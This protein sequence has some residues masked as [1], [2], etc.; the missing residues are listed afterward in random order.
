ML[1]FCPREPQPETRASA[2]PES[3]KK[4]VSLGLEVALESGIGLSSDHEDEAY[5]KAGA[6]ISKDPRS[7]LQEAGAVL[8]VRPPEP[9]DIARLKKGTLH[10]SFLNP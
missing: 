5:E 2:D 10:V 3:V 6:R 4:L 9:G 1:V 7:D 8:R